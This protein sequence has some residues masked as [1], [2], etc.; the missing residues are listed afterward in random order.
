MSKE[1]TNPRWQHPV[2]WLQCSSKAKG[3]TCRLVN[4][5]LANVRDVWSPP[6]HKL[7]VH[8]CNTSSWEVEAEDQKFV[9]YVSSSIQRVQN[10]ESRMRE[11]SV[12]FVGAKTG[13]GSESRAATTWLLAQT[14][15]R[16]CL[17]N[18]T[19]K[20]GSEIQGPACPLQP[21]RRC[22]PGMSSAA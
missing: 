22:R 13:G 3:W 14:T 18:K 20:N 11:G 6:P 7:S 12:E 5:K 9:N 4:R 19:L 2:K 21:W 10:P 1:W 15:V 16:T 8:V 17:K